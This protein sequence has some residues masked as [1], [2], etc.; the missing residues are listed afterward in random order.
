MYAHL[1][2]KEKQKKLALARKRAILWS[3]Q[4]QRKR[5]IQA[6]TPVSRTPSSVEPQFYSA[7][8]ELP[9]NY[10]TSIPSADNATIA[11]LQASI[12]DLLEQKNQLEITIQVLYRRLDALIAQRQNE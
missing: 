4:E 5:Q 11:A 6:T 8:S 7:H 12:A 9:P 3:S 1:T 2:K 10:N